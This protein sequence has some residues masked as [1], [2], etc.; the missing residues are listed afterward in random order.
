MNRIEIANLKAIAKAADKYL[1][2]W[3]ADSSPK[4]QDQRRKELSVWVK[5][6]QMNE[7]KE[8]AG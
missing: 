8:V 7:T 6:Y 5:I 3:E 4:V 2:S 1:R